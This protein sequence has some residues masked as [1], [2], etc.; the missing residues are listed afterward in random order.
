MP[1]KTK[2]EIQEEVKEVLNQADFALDSIIND[3]TVPRNIKRIAQ[4]SKDLLHSQQYTLAVNASNA[5]SL[6]EDLSQDPNC[7]MHTRTKI[8]QILSLLEQIRDV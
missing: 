7:P 3:T 4:E 8:Y 2:K 6:L 1:R 5:I